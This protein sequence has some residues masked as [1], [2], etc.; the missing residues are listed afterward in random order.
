M[1]NS[2]CES[3]EARNPTVDQTSVATIGNELV[4][5]DGWEL[6]SFAIGNLDGGSTLDETYVFICRKQ[7]DMRSVNGQYEYRFCTPEIN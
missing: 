6:H 2:S 1:G 5:K 3:T 7:I 4:F